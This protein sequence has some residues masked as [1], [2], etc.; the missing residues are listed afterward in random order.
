MVSFV[1]DG[2]FASTTV[3]KEFASPRAEKET[4]T[5]RNV[6]R[7]IAVAHITCKTTEK[8]RNGDGHISSTDRSQV[9]NLAAASGVGASSPVRLAYDTAPGNPPRYT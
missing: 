2:T 7:Y 8:G 1:S 3:G 9:Y 4:E 6:T 5:S